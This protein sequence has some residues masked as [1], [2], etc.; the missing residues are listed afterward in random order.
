MR[1][2]FKKT[3]NFLKNKKIFITG[4]TGSFGS[5]LAQKLLKNTNVGKIIIFSR[6]EQKQYQLK[7]IL[8][9]EKVRF[10]LGDV[11]DKQ[12]LREAI[13]NVDYVIHAA[14]LK[15][16]DIA[17]YNPSEA[18]KTNIIGTQNIIEVA[19]E[20]NIKKV[21][22]LSTDKAVSP[23]NLYGSTKLSAE[24]L[25]V[26][27]N[28]FKGRKNIAFSVVRYGNVLN[29]NG[30][31]YKYF[32][33]LKK[34]NEKFFPI[35]DFDMTRFFISIEQSLN[36]VLNS[37]RLSEGGEV[38]IPKMKSI[39]I[40]DLA[41]FVDASAKLKKIGIRPG[42]KIHEKL[43][44]A[45]ESNKIYDLKNFFVLYSDTILSFK[46]KNK[47]LPKLLKNKKK[48]IFINGYESNNAL[49][50]WTRKKFNTFYGIKDN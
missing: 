5:N 40:V 18:I 32:Q 48:T 49:I 1:S 42:E 14:A 46:R 25:L 31:V 41:K 8:N 43:F 4:G 37:L 11:R 15:H 20:K 17:E 30:S 22:A 36:F 12:R 26:S 50:K 34:N 10:F 39:K 2:D 28:N 9:S 45:D 27:A 3:Y 47:N 24:K 33:E 23:I 6:D 29:S 21:L 13:N 16:V 7:K 19:L 38:F 35:T 44:S